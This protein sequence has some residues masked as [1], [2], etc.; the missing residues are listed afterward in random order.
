MFYFLLVGIFFSTLLNHN[1]KKRR[2]NFSE[3]LPEEEIAK[4]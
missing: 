2:I 1:N 4:I 3:K